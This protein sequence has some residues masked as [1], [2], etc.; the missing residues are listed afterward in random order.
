MKKIIIKFGNT[1]IKKHKLHQYKRPI[2]IKNIGIDKIL[3]SNKVY[4]GKK[5]FK[6]FICYKD[7]K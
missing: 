6:Y 1:E 2:S 5:G 4:F 3:V 7:A